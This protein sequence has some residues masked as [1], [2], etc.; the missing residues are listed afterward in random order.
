[1]VDYRSF[2]YHDCSMEIAHPGLPFLKG[3][4]S[5]DLDGCSSKRL[6]VR[7]SKHPKFPLKQLIVEKVYGFLLGHVMLSL[8]LEGHLD[9]SI[10]QPRRHLVCNEDGTWHTFGE[11]TVSCLGLGTDGILIQCAQAFRA[12]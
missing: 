12:V 2:W 9:L 8:F 1:M 3:L 10:S 4:V 5:H 11:R 7:H 6:I